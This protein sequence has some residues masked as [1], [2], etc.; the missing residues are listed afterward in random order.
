MAIEP[1]LRNSVFNRI[2]RDLVTTV[3]LVGDLSGAIGFHV[4]IFLAIRFDQ[5]N[6]TPHV[7]LRLKEGVFEG[8]LSQRGALVEASIR[9]SIESCAITPVLHAAANR[10]YCLSHVT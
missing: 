1:V 3:V 6:G 2:R 9:G 5:V 4:R 8:R 10:V 7:L